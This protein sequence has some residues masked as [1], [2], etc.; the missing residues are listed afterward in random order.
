MTPS[1]GNGRGN[2]REGGGK[3]GSGGGKNGGAKV[4]KTKGGQKHTHPGGSASVLGARIAR[5]G[6]FQGVSLILSNLLHFASILYV[7][8]RLGAGNLGIYSLLL[9]WS[10]LIT[11]VFH[12]FSKP[13]TLRRVFGQADD[14]DAGSEGDFGEGEEEEVSQSPQKSLGT[15]M[16]WAA[17]M[18]V[19]GGGLTILFRAPIADVINVGDPRLVLWAGVLGGVGALFKLCDIV[20]WFER[21]P[22]TFIIVD[23]SRPALNLVLMA[24]LINSKHMGVR[25]AIEGAAIGTSIATGLS[26]IALIR[27]AAISFRLSE[28]KLILFRGLGRTPITMSMWVIQNADSYLLSQFVDHSQVGYYKFAQNLGFVVSFLPQGFRIAMRPLRKAALFQAV[29]DQYGTAVAKGQLLAYFCLVCMTA[30]L[31]MVLGGTL[32]LHQANSKFQQA[33][34]LIPITAAA[35]T[36]PA[37]FRTINGQTYFPHKRAWFIASVVFAA[38]SYVGWMYL[39][40]GVMKVGIIG[41][42]IAAVLAFG[43][44]CI[45][46]F[47]RGQR[48]PSPVQFPYWGIARA[49]L[50]GAAVA[51]FFKYVHFTNK[52][53]QLGEIAALMLL[54]ISALFFTRVIP[55]AHRRPLL[56][57]FTTAFRRRPH[58]FDR[59]QGLGALGDKQLELLHDAVVNRV[60]VEVF[61]GHAAENG[62]RNGAELGPAS[63]VDP[64]R[65]VKILRKAGKKGGIPVGQPTEYDARIAKFLFSDQPTAA[66]NAT[67]RSLVQSG[68]NSNDLRA[69]EDLRDYLEKSPSKVWENSG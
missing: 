13:G 64:E 20:I 8:H 3:R 21:R 46:L 69:L 22:I 40:L 66:S 56:H 60:P 34:P 61:T 18:G 28:L 52:W 26:V 23:A 14:D 37:L 30:I 10:G 31:A 41:T 7:A 63:Q 16:I 42:P 65:L 5:Y 2:K 24:Y 62:D 25:G 49:F 9:F 29:R 4:Y 59:E 32:I 15:G 57:I 47:I 44:S 48:G 54:W 35:M 36:M 33:A 55:K 68:A 38:L 27:S 11:Q 51:V 39:L 58:N 67:M 6:A 19:V 1:G 53:I 45:F 50:M 43:G 17:M 12:V